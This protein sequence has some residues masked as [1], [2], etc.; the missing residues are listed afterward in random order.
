MCFGSMS[1]GESSVLSRQDA[2]FARR[3][4]ANMATKEETVKQMRFSRR[5]QQ[6]IAEGANATVLRT[7]ITQ[8]RAA[9]C[10]KSKLHA[11]IL[12]RGEA[13][14][15]QVEAQ[16]LAKTSRALAAVKVNGAAEDNLEN[17]CHDAKSLPRLL[18]SI[19]KLPTDEKLPLDYL[20]ASGRITN[21][22]VAVKHACASTLCRTSNVGLRLSRRITGHAWPPYGQ[23]RRDGSDCVANVAGL[24]E[25]H[26]LIK[27]LLRIGLQELM[28]MAAR[29]DTLKSDLDAAT[30]GLR[31]LIEEARS[32]ELEEQEVAS[33]L[34]AIVEAQ[35]MWCHVLWDAAVT[36]L[37]GLD[38]CSDDVKLP[39]SAESQPSAAPETA[40]KMTFTLPISIPPNLTYQRI[41]LKQHDFVM[42]GGLGVLI[43]ICAVLGRLA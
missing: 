23:K 33:C 9:G 27:E 8:A 24:T 39:V 10:E 40:S 25:E 26:H 16:E 19:S 6:A 38:F 18:A 31:R 43:G 29:P 1:S 15:P 14:L 28:V 37:Q 7:A 17:V 35:K 42:I 5:L 12:R 2:S 36:D 4:S 21:P 30:Q 11:A 34:A 32:H 13:L 22:E 20:A 3:A 41:S